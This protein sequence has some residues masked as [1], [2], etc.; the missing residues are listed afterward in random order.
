[1]AFSHVAALFETGGKETKREIHESEC[2]MEKCN[3]TENGKSDLR[4]GTR[5]LKKP[6]TMSV[7]VNRSWGDW[8]VKKN[9]EEP[10]DESLILFSAMMKETSFI[11]INHQ[12]FKF[13]SHISCDRRPCSC[14]WAT[15][16]FIFRVF[17][18][19]TKHFCLVLIRVQQVMCD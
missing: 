12:L 13:H 19:L 11:T 3:E 10:S 6:S 5:D 1:M 7:F 17:E 16:R 18:A 4:A 8:R 9:L 2:F 14:I 15:L